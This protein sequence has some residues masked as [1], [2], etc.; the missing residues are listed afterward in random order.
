MVYNLSIK[1]NILQNQEDFKLEPV[2]QQVFIFK[3]GLIKKTLDPPKDNPED[4][5]N[6]RTVT[7]ICLF[8]GCK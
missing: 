8:K 2:S 7:V 1:L 5:N 6:F 4:I 3:F